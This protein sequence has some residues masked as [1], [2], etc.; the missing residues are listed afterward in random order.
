MPR[1]CTEPALPPAPPLPPVGS[2]FSKLT[3]GVPA[4]F[5]SNTTILLPAASFVLV[6]TRMSLPSAAAADIAARDSKASTP[7]ARNKLFFTS[8][9]LVVFMRSTKTHTSAE[10]SRR[11]LEHRQR[12][13]CDPRCARVS[14]HMGCGALQKVTTLEDQPEATAF[15]V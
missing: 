1:N 12:T 9:L 4:V 11:G 2:A 5:S 13:L 15:A 7:A 14:A 10:F 3:E 8:S 6:N